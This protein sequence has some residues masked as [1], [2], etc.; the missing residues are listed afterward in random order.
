MIAKFLF[1]FILF[2]P[3]AA[4]QMI[5]IGV[6]LSLSGENAQQGLAYEQAIPLFE[7]DLLKNKA[8]LTSAVA[9]TLKDDQ[10][11]PE[12][13]Q[14]L[15]LDLYDEGAQAI[16]C[17][18]TPE[19]SQEVL[20]SLAGSI[21]LFLLSEELQPLRHVYSLKLSLQ[22]QFRAVFLRL[23]ALNQVKLAVM[24]A[25]TSL[26]D[27]VEQAVRALSVPGGIQIIELNRYRLTEALTPD[28][29]WV[30]TRLPDAVLL[31]DDD[32]ERTIR[33]YK[34]LRDRGFEKNVYI[35]PSVFERLTD[36]S[37]MR[38]ALTLV[39]A[40]FDSELDNQ[41]SSFAQIISYRKAY[42]ERYGNTD[43]RGY[44]LFDALTII[45]LAAEQT[46][47]YGITETSALRSALLESLETLRY[48]NGLT[49]QLKMAYPSY[50]L[51]YES[52][53]FI[54]IE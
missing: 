13:T 40:V 46:L 5:N 45:S 4:A 53:R 50:T 2:S 20:E 29:L 26:A 28:A 3:V 9:I 18:Q 12:Q 7:A 24:T 14:K 25:D 36:K 43:Y 31:W 17:C 11:D 27:E 30:A 51:S 23:A 54:Q 42:E 39:A 10:S 47:S 49:G 22:E 41:H 52:M 21:P 19:A 32:V 6:I 15:A 38:A 16:I 33:A 48:Q 37:Q 1:V 34:A 44:E 8:Y 35:N